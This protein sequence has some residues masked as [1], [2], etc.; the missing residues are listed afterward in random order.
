MSSLIMLSF[1]YRNQIDRAQITVYRLLYIQKDV[2]YRY[3]LVNVITLSWS[4]S[5]HIK[6]LPLHL[7][8]VFYGNLCPNLSSQKID[9]SSQNF[10]MSSQ[11]KGC[12]CFK[13]SVMFDGGTVSE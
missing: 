3:H 4:Q 10:E 11:Q 2:V 13:A 8:K 5:D 9:L 1:Y 6:W 7:T 12:L